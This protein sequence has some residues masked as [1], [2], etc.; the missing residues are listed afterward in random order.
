[1]DEV[2]LSSIVEAC[3]RLGRPELLAEKLKEASAQQVE[4]TGAHTFGSLIKA[5]GCAGDVKGIWRTWREMRTRHV[6]PTSITVGCMVEAVVSNGD[7]EGGFDLIHELQEDDQCRNVLNSVIYCSVLK[8]FSREKKMLKVVEV[9]EEMLARRVELSIV[10]YNTLIDACAR[11]NQMDLAP[12]FFED[13]KGKD[14]RPNLITYSALLKGHCQSG[15]V[16]AGFKVL[17][18]M[19]QETTLKPDEIM[20][21]SMM[22]GCAQKG[23]VQEGLKILE[24]MV[25]DGVKPS[26]F[27]LSILVK[28][29]GYK[30]KKLDEAFKCCEDICRKY[31]IP[32]LN[33]HVYTN[34]IQACV[35]NRDISRGLRTFEEMV[36]KERVRPELRT[37][38]MLIKGLVQAGR[39]EQAAGVLRA[40]LGL[41]NPI[42]FLAKTPRSLFE[43]RQLG[44]D[45]AG[46]VLSALA[47]KKGDA[48]AEKRMAA[49]LLTDI[50]RCRT[51]LRV[52]SR[53]V[54]TILSNQ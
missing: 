33:V 39:L 5:Y 27:T 45:V 19:R 43:C 13:M 14:V 25:K 11:C 8:G 40:G 38:T 15:D 17:K 16:H 20:Y 48:V 22:D 29:W 12:K 2:L 46:E 34:L 42:D 47:E 51:D 7:T 3:V 10:T 23:M 24:E 49:E 35:Y 31:H 36:V 32:K 30:A 18:E 4:I 50:R 1:M 52:D 28:I 54:R 6:K 9:Y 53:T 44:M 41:P 26:N 21:N 37:Y